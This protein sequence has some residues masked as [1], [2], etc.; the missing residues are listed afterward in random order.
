MLFLVKMKVVWPRDMPPEDAKA[1]QVAERNYSADLQ[2][3]GIW[4]HLW[5]IS[6]VFGNISVFDVQSHEEL[7]DVLTNLP[8]F[9]FITLEITPLSEH[10]GR[11]PDD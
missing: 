1:L 2:R 9:P 10:P 7:H 8:F 4:K 6:G 5:R 3:K 11:V